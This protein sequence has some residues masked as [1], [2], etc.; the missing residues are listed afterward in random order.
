MG[1][2]LFTATGTA[3]LTLNAAGVAVVIEANKNHYRGAPKINASPLAH[4]TATLIRLREN[5]KSM[6]R[7]A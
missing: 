6:P 1:T 7:G 3:T 5:R 4:E 2:A